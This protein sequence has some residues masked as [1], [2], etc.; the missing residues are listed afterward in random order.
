MNNFTIKKTYSWSMGHRLFFY[1]GNCHNIHGHTYKLNA[2]FH[3]KESL[4]SE[5]LIFDYHVINKVLEEVIEP[6][7]HALALY[8]KDPL[9]DILLFD[10]FKIAKFKTDPTTEAIAEF[11]ND[12][13]YY[14]RGEH[15]NLEKIEV[16]VFE[17]EV[18]KSSSV[19][20]S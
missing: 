17:S 9:I 8:E 7:D 11:I 1:N 13:L 3:F 5:G 6:L 10:T 15:K 18:T 14:L 4:S 16:E 20:Y 19:I 12:R 2:S